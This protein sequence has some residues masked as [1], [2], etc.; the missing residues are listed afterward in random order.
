MTNLTDLVSKS[1]STSPRASETADAKLSSS[2]GSQE[3]HEFNKSV[4]QPTSPIV[5]STNLSESSTY[6]KS[7]PF[8][9]K[10][11]FG[12][13]DARNPAVAPAVSAGTYVNELSGLYRLSSQDALPRIL[14]KD[15]CGQTAGQPD[16]TDPS[17]VYGDDSARKSRTC[18]ENAVEQP[19]VRSSEQMP[20]ADCALRN[21][22]DHSTDFHMSRSNLI[23]GPERIFDASKKKGLNEAA[24][25]RSFSEGEDTTKSASLCI[26]QDNGMNIAGSDTA[27]TG[28]FKVESS[29]KFDFMSTSNF[30]KEEIHFFFN[31]VA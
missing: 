26:K 7:S 30:E 31:C 16:K 22:V 9:K 2:A 24:N 27:P 12:S 18:V 5:Q 20:L 29:G 13:S 17:V 14:T 11:R 3:I 19:E 15:N 28:N 21:G 25:S 1:P 10:Y 4:M 8:G 23:E 6:H